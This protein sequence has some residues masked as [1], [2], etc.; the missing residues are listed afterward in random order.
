MIVEI[1]FLFGM[2]YLRLVDFV[3]IGFCVDLERF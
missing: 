3:I 2:S 1:W